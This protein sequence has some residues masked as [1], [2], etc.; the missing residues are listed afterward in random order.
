MNCV[1]MFPGFGVCH[2]TEPCCRTQPCQ[3]VQPEEEI[4]YCTAIPQPDPLARRNKPTWAQTARRVLY[5]VLYGYHSPRTQLKRF[6]E[7]L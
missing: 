7:I 1:L 6:G 4:S 3:S 2:S 5:F